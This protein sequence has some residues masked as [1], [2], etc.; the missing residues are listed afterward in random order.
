MK[1]YKEKNAWSLKKDIYR[2]SMYR[3]YINILTSINPFYVKVIKDEL[4]TVSFI[5]WNSKIATVI[6]LN[7]NNGTLKIFEPAVY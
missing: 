3:K 5:Y 7:E 6:K 4:T 2:G 1:Q